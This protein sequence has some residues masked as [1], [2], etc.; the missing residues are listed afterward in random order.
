MGY[1]RLQY[2]VTT[3]TEKKFKNLMS[4]CGARTMN[5]YLDN[6]LAL[7]EWAIEEKRRGKKILSAGQ[8]DQ[9]VRELIMPMLE[10][11]ALHKI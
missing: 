9:M 8:D 10:H 4:I 5:S 6:A 7:M 3:E 1:K 11:A 2:E